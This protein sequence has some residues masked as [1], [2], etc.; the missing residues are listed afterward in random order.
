MERDRVHINLW[1]SL[2]QKQAQE[3]RAEAAQMREQIAHLEQEL[4]ERPVR[5]VQRLVDADE[6]QKYKDEADRAFRSREVAWQGL[7]EIRLRHR[8]GE[9]GRCRC[10]LRMDRCQ[11][12]EI[13]GKYPALVKWEMEQVRR[14]PDGAGTDCQTTTPL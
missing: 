8:E 6:L 2:G 5:E 4:A 7:C 10:G 1:R 3:H 11:I 13:V 12:A 9:A 14:M